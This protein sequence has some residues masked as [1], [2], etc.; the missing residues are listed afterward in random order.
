MDENEPPLTGI[1]LST[2]KH[3]KGSENNPELEGDMVDT[4]GGVDTN[5]NAGVEGAKEMYLCTTTESS[6]LGNVTTAKAAETENVNEVRNDALAAKLTAANADS[7][8][9]AKEQ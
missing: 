7:E 4:I 9:L 3:C 1:F 5:M 8:I 6:I 2:D